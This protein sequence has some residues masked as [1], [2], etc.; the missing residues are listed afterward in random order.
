MKGKGITFP[1]ESVISFKLQVPLIVETMP[2]NA[3]ARPQQ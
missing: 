1:S 3:A 2:E